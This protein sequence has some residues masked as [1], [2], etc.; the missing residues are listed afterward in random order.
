MVGSEDIGDILVD[1]RKRRRSQERARTI[2]K[3]TYTHNIH[4]R[5]AIYLRCEE[6]FQC[7]SIFIQL[8]TERYSHFIQTHK[9][10][11]SCV[12]YMKIILINFPSNACALV[13]AMWIDFSFRK[14]NEIIQLLVATSSD[15][16]NFGLG[17]ISLYDMSE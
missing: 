4:S 6:N 5:Y 14:K 1:R 16:A 7:R 8:P 10:S 2:K 11:R 3:N 9:F 17:M 15:K 13:Y 12:V